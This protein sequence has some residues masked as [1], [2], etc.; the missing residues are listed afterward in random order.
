M[1]RKLNIVAGQEIA[2]KIEMTSSKARGIIM[3][4]DNIKDWIFEGVV[5]KVTKKQVYVSMKIGEC[6]NSEIFVIDDNYKQKYT[7]GG[8]NYKLYLSKEDVIE[9]FK[10]NELYNSIRNDFENFENEN[11]SLE[12]L[13][14][15]KSIINEN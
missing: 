4:L 7:F 3:T 8:A 9:E 10:A 2:L 15:I 6:I 11:L 14:R 1:N 13:Q 5:T 12:Q